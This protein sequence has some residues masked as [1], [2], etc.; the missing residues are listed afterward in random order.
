LADGQTGRNSFALEQGY[1]PCGRLATQFAGCSREG[2]LSGAPPHLSPALDMQGQVSR[3]YTW[4]KSGRLIGVR[5]NV[6]GKTRYTY[7]PRDQVTRLERQHSYSGRLPSE[8]YRYD[9]LMNLVQSNGHGHQY[10][11]DCVTRIGSTTYHYDARGRVMSKTALRNGFR[12]H[13]WL[14]RWDDFDRLREMHTPEGERWRYTYD[15]FGRRVKKECFTRIKAGKPGSVTYLWQGATLTEEWQSYS[16]NNGGSSKPIQVN[17]WH[18]EPGT[19]KPLAKETLHQAADNTCI[20][21]KEG[22]YPIVTD[23]LGTPKEL[24]DAGGQCL[25]QAEHS[26]WGKTSVVFQRKQKQRD[27][28]GRETQADSPWPVVDCTL[29]FQNQWEDKESG[30]YYNFNRYYDPDSG[31][32][33]SQDPIG[34]AGGLRTH[35]Y[36]HDPMQWVDPLGLCKSSTPEVSVFD[37]LT[38]QVKSRAG[39]FTTP[40]NGAVLWT[41]YK[42]GNQTAAM[43]WAK[44]N[45]KFTIEMTPGG[46][47]LDSLNLYGPNSPVTANEASA[48]WK[49]ASEQFVAGASGRVN[50]FTRGTSVDPSKTFYGVELPG[51]RNNPSV[52]PKIT[53]RGY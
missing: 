37:N 16:D 9:A 34:L 28:F 48:L 19:F 51:L 29:R 15:A 49:V 32:Y 45:G 6:R 52:N 4:D 10:R 50:A 43:E 26:L 20:L 22:F 18:F 8:H 31:Q 44:A 11:R 36:V 41:G 35:G 3:R 33:L 30:L 40:R 27:S 1:D 14:Y 46:K 17:R 25:W 39:D 42:Q 12:P 13:T 2:V 21:E 5:D 7:D 23:H 24:F 53:Y 47:W 38:A